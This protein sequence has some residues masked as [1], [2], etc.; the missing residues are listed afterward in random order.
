M[1]KAVII[2]F[3]LVLIGVVALEVVAFINILNS[4]VQIE[5]I[6]DKYIK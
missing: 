4:K 3:M 2:L 5:N 1:R 6:E